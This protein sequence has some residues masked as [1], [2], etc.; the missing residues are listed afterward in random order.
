[1]EEGYVDGRERLGMWW[2]IPLAALVVVVGVLFLGRSSDGDEKAADGS[3]GATTTTTAQALDLPTTC[4]AKDRFIAVSSGVTPDR[5]PA[6]IVQALDELD[7]V[8]E[9]LAR[10]DAHPEMVAHVAVLRPAVAEGRRLAAGATS[11]QEL[12]ALADEPALASAEVI[13]ASAAIAN[14]PLRCATAG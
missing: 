10:D 9:V 4:Q 3:P 14:Y 12:A 2:L 6:A 1:M 7:S 13:D 11:P 8:L 5:D